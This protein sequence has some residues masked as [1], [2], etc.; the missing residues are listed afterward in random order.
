[1]NFATYDSIIMFMDSINSV[2][3]D[4]VT[5]CELAVHTCTCI[6]LHLYSDQH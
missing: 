1:M 4:F 3:N 2:K 6:M 5:V